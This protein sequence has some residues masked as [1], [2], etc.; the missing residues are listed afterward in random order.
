MSPLNGKTLFI[1]GASRG[2]GLAIARRAARDGANIVIAAKTSDPHPKLPGTIHSAAEEIVA[3]GGKAL[4]LVCD[5]RDEAQIEAAVAQAV[6]TFGGI[7]IC[8]NN[9]SAISL[10]P[11]LHT[12]P[13]RYDLMHQVNSRGTFFVSRA[14][15][16]HLKKAANPHVLTLS[17][18]LD[19]SPKFFAA[20]AA[21]SVAKFSMSL[22]AMA[23]AA[24]FKADGIAFNTLWPRTLI[25]T[26]A[27]QAIPG[28][29]QL[30]PR[31]RTPEIMAD[32]AYAILVR[33]SREFTGQHCIDDIVLAE[34]GITDLRGYRVQ[35]GDEELEID[36]FV[37]DNMP[38]PA[39]ILV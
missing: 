9:A 4:P 39:G 28:A 27:L 34:A 12:E 30:V 15:V 31:A 37:P 14:C 1:S 16:P 38:P 20:H 22:Y 29:M 19:L 11:T 7:D 10:T 23:M 26:V 3:A 25:A 21:Y 35:P 33:N 6:A 13:K 36:L 18:P 5:I 24:E 17:P 2:I 8:I 32:A